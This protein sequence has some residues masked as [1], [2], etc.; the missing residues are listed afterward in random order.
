MPTLSLVI[1]TLLQPFARL[2]PLWRKP[3]CTTQ[4][5]RLQPGE[6]VQTPFVACGVQCQGDMALVAPK[7]TAQ[8]PGLLGHRL[9]VVPIAGDED[10]RQECALRVDHSMPWNAEVPPIE[11]SFRAACEYWMTEDTPVMANCPWRQVDAADT[12]ATRP[13]DIP[14]HPGPEQAWQG[15][16]ETRRAD[17]SGSAACH[18]SGSPS[19]GSEPDRWPV[20]GSAARPRVADAAI[21]THMPDRNH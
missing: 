11:F 4:V 16:W 20:A 10:K 3:S 17:K 12:C 13:G 8:I 15:D 6:L 5:R 9:A 18:G 1:V 21:P 14:R 2:F 7:L 19:S